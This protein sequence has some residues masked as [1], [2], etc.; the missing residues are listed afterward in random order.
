MTLRECFE[1]HPGTNVIRAMNV[2]TNAI[3]QMN[4]YEY[5][6]MLKG[7][8]LGKIIGSNTGKSFV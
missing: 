6:L 7:N 2:H 1:L 3:V 8:P 5:N 4:T